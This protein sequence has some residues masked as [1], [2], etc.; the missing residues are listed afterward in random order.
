M[1]SLICASEIVYGVPKAVQKYACVVYM[2]HVYVWDMEAEEG[3]RK[4]AD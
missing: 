3:W 1:F 4:E 2:W